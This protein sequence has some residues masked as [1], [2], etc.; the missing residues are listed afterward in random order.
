MLYGS[1]GAVGLISLLVLVAIVGIVAVAVGF[2]FNIAS[3]IPESGQAVAVVPISEQPTLLLDRQGQRIL[4]RVTNPADP[5]TPWR[6]LDELPDVL[7]Q[8]TVAI[9]DGRYFE[10]P[11]FSLPVLGDALTSAI[12]NGTLGFNDPIPLYL[13]RHVIV[14]LHQ[15]PLDHPDRV[16][17]DTIVVME[18]RRRF[19]REA[20][21]EW[22]LNAALYGNGAY[23]IETAAQ[24]YL[25]KPATDLVLS[26]AALLA[27]VP[28]NPSLNPF[29]QPD[30]AFEQQEIVLGA[31]AAYAMVAPDEA[32]A[33]AVRLDVTR[34][35]AP[36]DVVA[37]HYALAAR[38]QAEMILNEAGFDG[39]RLVA[40]GG[41]RIT[42]ALDLDLQYQAECVLRTHTIRLA[43]VDPNFIYATTI[44]EPCVAAEYLPDLASPDIGV[45]HDVNNGAVVVLKPPTG[46]ILAYVGSVDYWNEAIGGPLDSVARYY[47]PGSM[48]RPYVYLTALSQGYTAATMALDVPQEFSGVGGATVSVSSQDGAYRGPISLRE[49]LVLDAAPATTQIMNLV[50]PQDVVR[51]AHTLGLNSLGDSPGGYD[52]SLAIEG[53]EAA[54][55]DLTY[56][57]GVLANGG[58]M[59]GAHIPADQEQPGYRTLDPVM[60]LRIE[61]EQGDLL[62]AYEPQQRDT[63]DPALAY[64]MNHIMGDRE[65]RVQIYGPSNVYDIGRPAAVVGGVNVERSALWTVGYTPQISIGVWTGNA[66]FSSTVRLDAE[67]GPAPIWN[68]I[69]QYYVNREGL[70]V[71]DW[72]RPATVVEQMVCK[73][74]GLLPSQYCPVVTEVFAQGTQPARQDN[75]YTMVEVNRENGKRATASTPRDLVEQR[76]YFNYPEEAQEWAIAQGIT[77]P[78]AEYDAV[79]P[80]PVFGPVAVLEP[81]SLAY[82][83][84]TVD[85]RGNATLPG[86]QYYQ[87]AYG[88]GLNPVDWTQIGSQV[89]TPARG[90][91]LGRWDTTG[92]EGLYSLRLTVVTDAQ[93]VQQSV[94]QLTVDNTPP[95]VAIDTPQADSEVLVAGLNPMLDVAVTY[96]DN[97]GVAQVVYYLDGDVVNSAIEPPFDA[98]VVLQSIGPHSLWAEAFDSAGNSTVSERITFNVRRTTQ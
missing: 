16:L 3:V 24:F 13:A 50:S 17:T 63:L 81:A 71:V 34:A 25:G 66:D 19:S 57:Q 6:T 32:Q 65:L 64:L 79:G 73:V 92:L 68:G 76:V 93:E 42:T 31:L 91:L 45:Q 46:E 83:R 96:S 58:R 40:G 78:P 20:L 9:E 27:G 74:S 80:P 11:G 84:G 82:I 52:V 95:Q 67:N 48:L 2:Y 59:V 26:E 7:W 69:M 21:L 88:A 86:F 55:V 29:D 49:A 90:A 89:G 44:G 5:N 8:A 98:S 61:D 97:V 47:D 85:I 41:L 43:G 51:T 37:P 75:Y 22:Y 53:G 56:S 28:A 94:I 62:W 33:A 14:P 39:A 35:L 30:A 10:R 15:M 87:L 18:L 4:Y 38:R 77:G 60:V 72:D 12:M 54:L 70:P 1:L 23:G 36:N